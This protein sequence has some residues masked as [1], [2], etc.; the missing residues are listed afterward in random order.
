MAKLVAFLVEVRVADL[1]ENDEASDELQRIR[2]LM[3]TSKKRMQRRSS[4]TKLQLLQKIQSRLG[5]KEAILH[6]LTN[7]KGYAAAIYRT[8]NLLY[9]ELQMERRKSATSLAFHWDGGSY[10]GL[11]VNVGVVMDTFSKE[12]SYIKPMAPTIQNIYFLS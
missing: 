1:I 9:S 12:L 7:T 5:S 10:D 8:H 4:L 11:N 3:G 2:P 6:G